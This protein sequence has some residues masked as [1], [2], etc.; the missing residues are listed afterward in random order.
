MKILSTRIFTLFGIALLAVAMVFLFA[1]C[2]ND[3]EPQNSSGII[4]GKESV[5]TGT[6]GDFQYSYETVTQKVTITGYTGSGGDLAIPAEIDG[7]PVT[8]I[9]DDAFYSKQLTS[10][11]IGNSVT[12]IGDGAFASNQLTSVTIPNSVT[13]IGNDAFS[14]NELTSVTIGNSVTYI[15][16]S[17]FG[18]NQLT[19]V[20]IP[21]SVTSIGFRAFAWN[22][23]TSVTIGNSVTHI[24]D[25]AFISNQLTAVIIPN[26]VTEIGSIAFENNQLT[27]VTIGANVTLGERAFNDTYIISSGFETTYDNGDKQA[28][29][30]TRPNTSST[31]WTKQ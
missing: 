12:Y 8:A 24:G 13:Y 16:D 20:V 31:T 19:S 28:G 26:S 1:A 2:Q 17:A 29:K 27:S 9:G 23:L 21:N 10:V 15:G 6:D 30:Y 14:W 11:T 18:E 4:P 25:S 22:K 3:P 5:I 7:K